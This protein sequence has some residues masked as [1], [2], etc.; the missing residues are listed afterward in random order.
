MNQLRSVVGGKH[1]G[2][3]F[4]YADVSSVAE[5]SNADGSGNKSNNS[6]NFRGVGST[7]VLDSFRTYVYIRRLLVLQIPVSAWDTKEGGSYGYVNTPLFLGNAGG[8]GGSMCNGSVKNSSVENLRDVKGK[9]YSGIVS[10]IWIKA[11]YSR[12]RILPYWKNSSVQEQM[13]LSAVGNPR[14]Q[15]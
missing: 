1:A 8:F 3:F 13:L 6:L 12:Q 7:T 2:G 15:L 9:N 4:G 5:I 14:R 10:D 11:E